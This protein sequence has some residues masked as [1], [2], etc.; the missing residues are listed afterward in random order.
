MSIVESASGSVVGDRPA[1]PP[2]GRWSLARRH[3]RKHTDI[4][5]AL[6]A[7]WIGI[8]IVLAITAQWLPLHSYLLPAGQPNVGPNWSREFFGTDAAGRSVLSRVIFG[9]RVSILISVLATAI[10]FCVGAILG[11]CA[12]YF[13]PPISS[14]GD[15]IANSILSIPSLLLL[16]AVV[17]ALQP[18]IPVIT[19]ACAVIFVPAFLRLTRATAATQ[20]VSDYVQIARGLGASPA[21][22]IF[23][24]LLPNTAPSLISYAALV[25]PAV[26]ILEGS[27]S[28][29]GFGIQSPTPSWGN[30]IALGS[31][32]LTVDP[33]QALIPCIFLFLTVFALNTI[34]DHLRLRFSAGQAA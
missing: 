22:I 12:A 7:S 16:L 1:G 21:R 13:G 11:V 34:G 5:L 24:E 3:P 29:L 2:D 27:L 18:S 9:A 32:N 6:A 33:W 30:M 23:R 17:L 31:Q 26:M 4:A 15:V 8:L 25:L 19:V 28:F 14:I 10:S 20:M